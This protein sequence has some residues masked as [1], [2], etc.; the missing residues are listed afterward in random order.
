MEYLLLLVVL[1][2]S[3]LCSVATYSGRLEYLANNDPVIT[4]AYLLSRES[5]IGKTEV[6]FDQF[7][8]GVNLLSDSAVMDTVNWM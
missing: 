8:L 7:H 2:E 6:G 3:S 1:D 4:T 5:A